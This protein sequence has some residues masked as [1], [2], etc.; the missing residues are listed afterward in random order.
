[1]V[2]EAKG[3]PNAHVPDAVASASDEDGGEKG[4]Q[5]HGLWGSRQPGPSPQ[6]FVALSPGV[7]K[8]WQGGGWGCLSPEEGAPWPE[9]DPSVGLDAD[10][11]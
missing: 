4:C 5:V 6:G 1:M 3:T 11:V 10:P 7:Q 8:G 9:T 2:I